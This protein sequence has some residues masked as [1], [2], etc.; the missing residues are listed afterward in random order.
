MASQ[1]HDGRLVRVV[2]WAAIA[3]AM[4]GCVTVYQPLVGLQRPIAVDPQT[5]DTFAATRVLVRCHPAEGVEPDVLCRN[6]RSSLSKQGATVTTEVVRPAARAAAATP[7]D[8]PPQYII[9]VT[10]KRLHQSEDALLALLCVFSFTLVPAVTEYTFGQDVSIRD[11]QGF[12]LAQQS[13]QERLVESFGLGVWALN[14]LID[15]LIRPKSEQVTGDG[16]KAEFTRD[17]HGHLAQLLYNAKVRARV[18]N[19][20]APEP[21]AEKASGASP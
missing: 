20:F 10:S 14:G 8:A 13:Y 1:L 3:I 19:N 21:V 15:L 18:M 7:S 16:Y 17:L 9:D 11:A 6:L 12:V 2:G 5:P 4:S